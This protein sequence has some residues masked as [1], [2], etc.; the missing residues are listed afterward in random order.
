MNGENRKTI[1][2]DPD[3]FRLNNSKKTRK[4]VQ[5]EKKTEI[6]IPKLN[7]NISLIRRKLLNR[8]KNHKNKEN[9]KN[10]KLKNN[11][12]EFNNENNL[13]VE[14]EL[15]YDD[16]DVHADYDDPE[17]EY[18]HD[19]D[20]EYSNAIDYF[21]KLSD[22]EL[23][24][25]KLLSKTI[26]HRE[27]IE[28]ININND[29]PYQLKQSDTFQ[30][31]N[32]FNKTNLNN[33][34]NKPKNIESIAND[35]LIDLDV[36]YG[37]LKNGI[38][39]TYKTWKNSI[40]NYSS[41]SESDKIET[42]RPPTPPKN[43]NSL[44]NLNKITYSVDDLFLD[45]NLDNKKENSLK[46]QIN[47]KLKKIQNE[48]ENADENNEPIENVTDKQYV[49]KIIKRKYT[50]GKSNK[51]RKIGVLIKGRQTKRNILNSYKKI[52]KTD[53]HQIKKYLKKHGLLKTGSSCPDEVLRK[54]YESAIL[55][56]EVTNI[57]KDI[58]IH[59]FLNEGD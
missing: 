47:D 22:K 56:G 32:L 42:I 44:N 6:N 36:P 11:L 43:T 54:I 26:K 8:I 15:N 30:Q 20:D 37:C 48:Q 24:R 58:L 25:K 10:Y 59:N 2:V 39:P 31:N 52:K 46:K 4:N 21:N 28:N 55:S 41:M 53:I 16:N 35:I 23:E 57:N 27:K 50:L 38:K 17:N 7:K 49:K 51:Y 19:H 14:M 5:K 33:T 40:K 29:I 1:S 12:N 45:E 3:L 18:D 13:D 34:I 9:N